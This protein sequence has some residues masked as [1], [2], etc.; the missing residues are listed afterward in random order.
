MFILLANSSHP[1]TLLR[2][3]ALAAMVKPAQAGSMSRG[4]GDRIFQ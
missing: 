3:E 2:A 4:V 1:F